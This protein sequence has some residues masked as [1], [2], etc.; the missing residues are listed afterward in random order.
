MT[1]ADLPD[2][3]ST[4]NNPSNKILPEREDQTRSNSNRNLKPTL[5]PTIPESPVQTIT[6]IL[7]IT[8]HPAHP[9][10]KSLNKPLSQIIMMKEPW[11]QSLT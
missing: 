8:H 11:H 7:K 5:I 1:G 9:S 2:D 3:A 6:P 4:T 10:S